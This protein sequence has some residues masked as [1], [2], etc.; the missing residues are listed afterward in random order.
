MIL[1]RTVSFIVCH[2]MID[3]FDQFVAEIAEEGDFVEIKKGRKVSKRK[4]YAHLMIY[5]WH[6]MA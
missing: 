6:V 2:I 1:V 5:R 3:S 4:A